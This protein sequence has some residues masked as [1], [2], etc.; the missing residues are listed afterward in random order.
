GERA[1]PGEPLVDVGNDVV[2]V[3]ADVRTLR[4]A[5]RG[6]QHGALLGDVDLLAGEHRVTPG[7]DAGRGGDSDEGVEDGVVDQVLGEVDAQV[8][9]LQQVAVGPT[10]IRIEQVAQ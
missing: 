1:Q 10:G 4:Q 6:V 9:R 7:L 8:G 5:Q 3:N 2:A